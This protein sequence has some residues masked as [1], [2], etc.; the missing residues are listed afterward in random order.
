MSRAS[1]GGAFGVDNLM[2]RNFAGSIP[3][4]P[5]IVDFCCVESG[6]VVELD[7]GQHAESIAADQQRTKLIEDRGYRILRF[8]NNEV[9]SNLEGVLERISEAIARPGPRPLPQAGEQII[10]RGN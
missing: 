2:A 9:L 7:G 10:K 5:F 4:G 3:I 6:L 1:C 8:W